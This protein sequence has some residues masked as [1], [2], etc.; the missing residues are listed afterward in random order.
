[1]KHLLRFVV[2]AGLCALAGTG[3]RLVSGQIFANY[4]LPNPFTLNSHGFDHMT[5]DLNTIREYAQHKNQIDRIEDLA[6]V[7]KFVNV[8]GEAGSVE[9]FITPGVTNLPDAN[10]VRTSATKLWGP[11]AMPSGAGR[12]RE[13]T[14]DE[15]AQLFTAAGK[16]ILLNEAKGDGVFEVY[17][18]GTVG[19]YQIEV[20]QGALIL[21]AGA[22][23]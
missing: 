22:H 5:V 8:G 14:W 21:V 10:A 4:N 1:M 7:G 11:A 13:I 2:L 15:S 17:A 16:Q 3:C 19:Q 18:L 20:R 23:R 12:I 9:V 6:L